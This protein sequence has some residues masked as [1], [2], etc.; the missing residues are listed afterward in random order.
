[1]RLFLLTFL[2]FLTSQQLLTAQKHDYFWAYGYSSDTNDTLSLSG[3]GLIDFNYRPPRLTREFL[4]I[5][6]STYCTT[7]ADSTGKLLFYSNGNS[8]YNHKRKLMENGDTINPG[9]VWELTKDF[10]YSNF[11]GGL[12]VPA[13]GLANHYYMIHSGFEIGDNPPS[14]LRV[15]PIYATLINMQANNGEGKVVYKNRIL[16]EGSFLGQVATKH[17]NGRDW[18]IITSSNLEPFFVRYLISPSG[19]AGP[20]YQRFGPEY[21]ISNSGGTM[22]FSNDGSTFI[23]VDVGPNGAIYL[24]DFDRCT[25]LL[26]APR[27]TVHR[28]IVSN[29]PVFSPNDRFVY[30]YGAGAGVLQLDAENA[31]IQPVF[32]DTV[33]LFD[34]SFY[35]FRFPNGFFYTGQMAP[36]GKIYSTPSA[37]TPF[38]HVIHRPNLP[39]AAADIENRGLALP[40]IIDFTRCH[41]PNYRL[42]ALRGSPCD[43]LKTPAAPG[44]DDTSYEALLERRAQRKPWP[45]EK[46]APTTPPAELTEEEWRTLTPQGMMWQRIKHLMERDEGEREMSDKR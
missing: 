34:R 36:D 8:I 25:G 43:T 16:L 26:S 45:V 30:L 33:Q 39:G 27:K 12:A 29:G 9:R 18:W 35:A 20:F 15:S 3:G 24:F 14:S 17:A 38:M 46:N 13:P 19:I 37:T 1:M 21:T 44:F 41:F 31:G 2:I 7:C 6:F 28:G 23:R 4:K 10:G 40:R 11:Y 32:S 5:G 22:A 42:G